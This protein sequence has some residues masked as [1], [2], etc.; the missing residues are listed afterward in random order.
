MLVIFSFKNKWTYLYGIF[1]MRFSRKYILSTLSKTLRQ[2]TSPRKLALT[3]ALGIVIAIFPVWGITTWICLGVALALRLNVVILQ[4]VNYIFF[5]LQ[6]MLILPFIKAGTW[7]FGLKPFPYEASELITM[8]Q[9]DYFSVLREIG[10]SVAVGISIW[11]LIAV[12]LFLILFFIGNYAFSRW[13]RV[14]KMS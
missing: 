9:A 1:G 3:C 11:A 14:P 2:G 8:L 4:L 7:I 6:L 13:S 12:P 10:L 5:P